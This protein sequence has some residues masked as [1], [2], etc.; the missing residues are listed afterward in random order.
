MDVLGK[1]RVLTI[2]I[3]DRHDLDHER[4]RFLHG[5]STD[6]DIVDEVRH[7]VA[8]CDGP[9]MVILDGNHDRDHVAAELELY[10]PMVT[11]GSLLLSQDGIIDKL[12]IFRAGRPGPLGANRDFLQRHPEFESDRERNQR[13]TLTHHPLGW[14]R[15]KA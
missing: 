1:G 11:P 3:L 7:E 12:W 9:V 14:M 10:A 15:R 13:F 4:I 6:P 8:K 2:D 5:S